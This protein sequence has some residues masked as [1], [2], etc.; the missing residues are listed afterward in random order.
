VRL[1]AIPALPVFVTYSTAGGS[2]QPGTTHRHKRFCDISTGNPPA[3]AQH[4]RPVRGD[5]NIEPN[6]FFRLLL[7]PPT[8]LR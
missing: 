8:P 5:T 3:D 7:N 6:E 4:H 2:A 1:S